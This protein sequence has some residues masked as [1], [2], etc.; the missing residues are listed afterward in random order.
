MVCKCNGISGVIPVFC[1]FVLYCIQVHANVIIR[2]ITVLRSK[3]FQ[4]PRTS[5]PNFAAHSKFSTLSVINFLRP[6]EPD[7]ICSI[8]CR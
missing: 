6:P 5:L 1:C 3:F 7:Q 4:I 8:C 2:E